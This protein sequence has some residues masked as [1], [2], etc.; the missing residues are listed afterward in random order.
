[1]TDIPLYP[2]T[3]TISAYA[4]SKTKPVKQKPVKPL[5]AEKTILEA[6]M[7]PRVSRTKTRPL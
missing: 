5:Y 2:R 6:G 4:Q 1:M 3:P 7:K